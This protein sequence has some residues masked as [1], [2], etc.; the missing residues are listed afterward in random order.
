MRVVLGIV[1]LSWELIVVLWTPILMLDLDILLI[2]RF[3]KSLF[4]MVIVPSQGLSG[5]LIRGGITKI[6]IWKGKGFLVDP[7]IKNAH[8][9]YRH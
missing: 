9:R 3:V 5:A 7:Q 6:K 8:S 4:N 1:C 2:C